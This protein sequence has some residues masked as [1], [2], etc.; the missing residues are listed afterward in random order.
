MLAGLKGD[1][2]QHRAWGDTV[3]QC[4]ELTECVG[5]RVT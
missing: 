1:Y 2:K 3:Q 4:E 5:L